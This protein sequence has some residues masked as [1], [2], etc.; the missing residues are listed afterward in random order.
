MSRC[1]CVFVLHLA[2]EFIHSLFNNHIL[3]PP[4]EILSVWEYHKKHKP[5]SLNAMGDLAICPHQH[6][7]TFRPLGPP[8][9]SS[10][11]SALRRHVGA[12]INARGLSRLGKPLKEHSGPKGAAMQSCAAHVVAARPASP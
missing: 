2:E 5:V 11:L 3:S 4:H 1:V 9:P 6:I 10:L 8:N 7:Y 12:A